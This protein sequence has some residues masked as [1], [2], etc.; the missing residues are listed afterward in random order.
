MFVS[1]LCHFREEEVNNADLQNLPDYI[2]SLASIM[3]ELSAVT[4]DQMVALQCLTVQL[5]ENFPK[6]PKPFHWLAIRAIIVALCSLA[7]SGGMFLDEFLS[8]VGK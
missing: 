3:R 4:K 7:E 5:I 8:N 6:L 1:H 2:E